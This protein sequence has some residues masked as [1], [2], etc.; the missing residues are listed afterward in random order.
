MAQA[1][2]TIARNGIPI[3]RIAD[4]KRKTEISPL[5]ANKDFEQKQGRMK[6]HFFEKILI[7]F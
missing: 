2:A 6:N 7:P 5:L 3:G 1:E 4:Y